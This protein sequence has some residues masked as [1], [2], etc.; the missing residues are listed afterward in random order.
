MFAALL[1]RYAMRTDSLD[2]QQLYRKMAAF[3]K[4]LWNCGAVNVGNAGAKF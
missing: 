1:N 2:R 3:F 4:E